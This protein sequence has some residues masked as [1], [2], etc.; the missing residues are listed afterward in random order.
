MKGKSGGGGS[1]EDSVDLPSPSKSAVRKA[2]SAVRAHAYRRAQGEFVAEED[3]REVLSVVASYRQSF[4]SPL[5]SVNMS[6]RSYLSSL[7]IQ[8]EVSQRLKRMVT[9]VDKL[10]ARE[11]GMDLSRMR[12]IGGC[13]VVLATDSIDDLYRL[14]EHIQN[15]N[16]STRLIDYVVS[17]RRSGYRALHLE[18]ERNGRTI[19]V[20]LRTAVM[21]KWAETAEAMGDILGLNFKWDGDTSVHGLLRLVSKAQQ[22]EERGSSLDEHEIGQL[23]L[24]TE[25]VTGLLK[26]RLEE[27]KQS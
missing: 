27:G 2:G 16:A 14:A 13:R 8:G 9:I 4:S 19:E 17:P 25:E 11:K 10:C 21:H 6:L 7:G 23:I 5:Q 20:Q 24:L 1:Q 18:L 26:Q 12:D 22:A 15:A 3:Q